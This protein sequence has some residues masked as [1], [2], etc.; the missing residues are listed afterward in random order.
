MAMERRDFFKTV[1]ATP[2]LAQLL[3][4]SKTTRGNFD[5]YLISDEPVR[6]LPPLFDNLQD[7][8]SGYG[9]DFTFLNSCSEENDLGKIFLQKGWNHVQKS[10]QA[11]LTLSFN[12]LHD[13][14]PPSFTLVKEGRIWDIRPHKLYSLWKNMNENGMPSSLLT[15]ASLRSRKSVLS[16]GEFVVVYK[17]G[18][19]ID[20]ISLKKN[21]SKSYQALS[22]KINV[23]LEDRKAW[24]SE[25]SCSHKICVASPPVSLAGERIICAPN[26]FLLEIQGPHSVDT[27]IG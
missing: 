11:D 18:H 21:L 7:Q 17:D 2:F 14:I 26:H 19:R 15:V 12:R 3:L 23:C 5:L 24:V 20:R 6:F 1:L 9:N 22:G 8:T 16:S 13:R 10:S 27:V 4:A 25:S